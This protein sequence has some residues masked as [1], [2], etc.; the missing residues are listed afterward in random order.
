VGDAKKK[1]R[2]HVQCR[3]I[4]PQKA[5]ER[6]GDELSEKPGRKITVQSDVRFWSPLPKGPGSGK[7]A[8]CV[9]HSFKTQKERG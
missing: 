7:A 6:Y 1:A 9:T 2:L 8:T 5:G 3:R 4:A